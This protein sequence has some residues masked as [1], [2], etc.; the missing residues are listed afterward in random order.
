MMRNI[1]QLIGLTS[2]EN[3]VDGMALRICGG[4]KAE[5]MIALRKEMANGPA[6]AQFRHRLMSQDCLSIVFPN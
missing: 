4:T 5:K 2:L 3:G 6:G 1:E